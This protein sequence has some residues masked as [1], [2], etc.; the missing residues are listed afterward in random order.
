MGQ[1]TDIPHR[2]VNGNA[3]LSDTMITVYEA[4]T[5]TLVPLFSD[6][7][8]TNALPYP[9]TVT[10][11]NP[12]PILY[13]GFAGNVRVEVTDASGALFDDDPYDAS[14]YAT[15]LGSTHSDKGAAIVGFKQASTGASDGTVRD[16]LIERPISLLDFVAAADKLNVVAGALAADAA[17]A[18]LTAAAVAEGRPA[19]IPKGNFKLA[20]QTVLPQDLTLVLDDGAELFFEDNTIESGLLIEADAVTVIGRGDAHISGPLTNSGGRTGIC[21]LIRGTSDVKL[22]GFATNGGKYGVMSIDND[23]LTAKDVIVRNSFLWGFFIAGTRNSSFADCGVDTTRG[24]G[25]AADCFKVTGYYHPSGIDWSTRSSHNLFFSDCWGRNSA[26]GQVFDII[27]AHDAVDDLHNIF[28][29]NPMGNN[30]FNGLLEMKCDESGGTFT[31][32]PIHDIHVHGGSYAGSGAEITGI[33]VADRVY[34]VFVDGAVIKDVEIGLVVAAEARFLQ[35]SDLTVLRPRKEGIRWEG[36]AGA[37]QSCWIIRPVVVDPNY[38]QVASTYSGIAI[39]NANNLSIVDPIVRRSQVT[40][41]LAHPYGI[42]IAATCVNVRLEGAPALS[43]HATATINNLGTA[44]RWP[45]ALSTAIS[46]KTDVAQQYYEHLRSNPGR[47]FY[48]TSIKLDNTEA[49]TVTRNI[50]LQARSSTSSSP[51]G[52]SMT[53]GAGAGPGNTFAS[54][55]QVLNPPVRVSLDQLVAQVQIGSTAGGPTGRVNYTVFGFVDGTSPS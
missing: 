33:Y 14:V 51:I 52:S 28:I 20:A 32:Y 8:L 30:C 34:N 15:D 49:S 9:L 54:Q 50:L 40:S 6:E 44:T 5:S 55:T 41:G 25:S 18:L 16:K 10:S 2:I 31:N 35:F 17:F 29:S 27:S 36:S 3:V 43:G 22:Q 21:I 48:V 26:A 53:T 12:I 23:R 42:S 37:A 13:H 39:S 1:I 4:G 47:A 19:L 45:M 7:A 38:G 24:V 46:I 11:G